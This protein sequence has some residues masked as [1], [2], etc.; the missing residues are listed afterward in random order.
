MKYLNVFD[1]KSALDSSVTSINH[2]DGY[3]P[4]QFEKCS[5]GGFINPTTKDEHGSIWQ[6][7]TT[8]TVTATYPEYPTLFEQNTL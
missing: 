8:G 6:F 7:P 1:D 3:I 2:G 4:P 5:S